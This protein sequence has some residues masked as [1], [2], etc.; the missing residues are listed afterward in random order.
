M[1]ASEPGS[2]WGD[3]PAC[4]AHV[5]DGH[6]VVMNRGLEGGVKVGDIVLV[7]ALTDEEIVD[8]E[9][10]DPLGRLETVR[11]KGVVVHVQERLAT[12]EATEKQRT[13]GRIITRGP[14]AFGS[15]IGDLITGRHRE[16][17]REEGEW[18]NIGFEGCEVGDL[19]R[20]LGSK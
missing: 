12:I 14:G 7:Y 15:T 19:V 6:R 3:K 18:V 1:S 10:G 11:G 5:V 2:G 8:P 17:L 4:I 20:Y 13:P 9:S 16:V